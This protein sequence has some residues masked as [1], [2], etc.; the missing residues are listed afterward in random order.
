V[1]GLCLVNQASNQTLKH[2]H[3]KRKLFLSFQHRSS[4]NFAYPSSF[5]ASAP[6]CPCNIHSGTYATCSKLQPLRNLMHS[7][8]VLTF[9]IHR[10]VN[11]WEESRSCWISAQDVAYLCIPNRNSRNTGHGID[12]EKRKTKCRI[13]LFFAGDL[14][15]VENSVR[16][17]D[18]D[19][20]NLPPSQLPITVN[21]TLSQVAFHRNSLT[22]SVQAQ[23]PS[24]LSKSHL[25][26]FISSTFQGRVED[27][28]PELKRSRFIIDLLSSNGTSYYSACMVVVNGRGFKRLPSTDGGSRF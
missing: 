18:R 27:A 12:Q 1:T 20:E 21:A 26:S 25:P 2:I 6:S 28:R 13:Y 14:F 24:P 10:A 11:T 8:R 17:S 22:W 5:F 7:T 16:L 9:L 4:V 15:G 23:V 3:V 19:F